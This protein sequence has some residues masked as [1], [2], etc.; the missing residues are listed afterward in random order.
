MLPENRGQQDRKETPGLRGQQVK[1]G[2]K[3]RLAH[4]AR[5]VLKETQDRKGQPEP[6]GQLE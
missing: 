5:Q 2:L 1:P 6:P 3:G 4:K